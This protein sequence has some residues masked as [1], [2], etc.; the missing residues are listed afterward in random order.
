MPFHFNIDILAYFHI[1]L[2][3]SCIKQTLGNT[4]S[5]RQFLY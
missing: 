3:S 1:L 2:T 4:G 5:I